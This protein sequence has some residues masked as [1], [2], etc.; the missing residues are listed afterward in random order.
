MTRLIESIDFETIIRVGEILCVL[1]FFI[2]MLG[3]LIM[4]CTVML[5]DL[6]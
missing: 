2:M 6:S 4:L 1:G 5:G 3:L